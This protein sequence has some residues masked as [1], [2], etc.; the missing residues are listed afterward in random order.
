M[1]GKGHR[2]TE[3]QTD[4]HNGNPPGHGAGLSQGCGRGSH[5]S[6]RYGLHHDGRGRGGRGCR[7]SPG[8]LGR[9]GPRRD[10]DLGSVGPMAM[11]RRR[12]AQVRS[13][14]SSRA[15]VAPGGIHGPGVG[16]DGGG[17]K[18]GGHSCAGKQQETTMGALGREGKFHG[19]YLPTQALHVTNW[20][21]QCR[22]RATTARPGLGRRS[23][24][25]FR[26]PASRQSLSPRPS[27]PESR[28]NGGGFAESSG[29]WS[30]DSSWWAWLLFCC[31]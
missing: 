16:G 18:Q 3:R 11:V 27:H 1:D 19:D 8:Q 4:A 2:A 13:V 23:S 17:N 12:R 25:A 20:S 31:P 26:L 30:G 6:R 21:Q 29:A 24:S 5:R 14:L 15:V 10:D 9:L 28:C 7:L 22:C